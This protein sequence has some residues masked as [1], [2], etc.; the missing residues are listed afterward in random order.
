MAT[1]GPG[2]RSISYSDGPVSRGAGEIGNTGSSENLP[3]ARPTFHGVSRL[4]AAARPPDAL[5]YSP[6]RPKGNAR[7]PTGVG[8]GS[9]RL[10]RRSRSLPQREAP[11]LRETEPEVHRVASAVAYFNFVNRIAEGLGVELEGS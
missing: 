2:A 1:E 4:T 7:R 3:R 9:D 8:R 11:P 5:P 6:K 10:K